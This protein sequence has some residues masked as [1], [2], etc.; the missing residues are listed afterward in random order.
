MCACDGG[1]AGG[2]WGALGRCLEVAEGRRDVGGGQ[3][4]G[5]WVGKSGED[6][7][8]SDVGGGRR[9]GGG[10]RGV[11]RWVPVGQCGGGRLLNGCQSLRKGIG[12]KLDGDGLRSGGEA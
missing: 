12:C 7:R 4:V 6:S 9:G 8:C 11:V 5:S 2:E 10:G 1:A 3:V